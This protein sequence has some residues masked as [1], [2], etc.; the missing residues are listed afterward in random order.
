[1]LCFTIDVSLSP[2]HTHTHRDGRPCKAPTSL[3]RS[4]CGL[5]VFLRDIPT[6]SGQGIEPSKVLTARRP[7]SPPEPMSPPSLRSR[8]TAGQRA[9]IRHSADRPQ[10]AG[11]QTLFAR[12][13]TAPLN[14]PSPAPEINQLLN[15]PGRSDHDVFVFPVSI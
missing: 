11:K 15:R 14:S 3:V 5:A 12:R 2:V 1:M 10:R 7:L 6:H 9:P 8:D 13:E 4:S